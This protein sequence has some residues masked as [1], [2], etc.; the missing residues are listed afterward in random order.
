MPNINNISKH[1]VL[2]YNIVNM[3]DANFMQYNMCAMTACDDIHFSSGNVSSGNV[4]DKAYARQHQ[5]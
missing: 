3:Y 1:I 5:E 2:L 4:L